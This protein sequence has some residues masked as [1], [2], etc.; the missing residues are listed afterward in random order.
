MWSNK[1]TNQTTGETTIGFLVTTF[2]LYFG[3][4]LSHRVRGGGLQWP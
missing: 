3:V 2:L 4:V 1:K